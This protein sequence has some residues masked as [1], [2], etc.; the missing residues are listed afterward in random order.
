[1]T[2]KIR[3]ERVGTHRTIETRDYKKIDSDKFLNDLVQQPWDL[4]SLEPNPTAM[5][6]AWK[7]LFMEIVDKHAPLK[8]KR[9][10][11]K[12]SPWITYDLMRKIYK[13]NY[14]KKKAIIENNAASW[15]QYKQARNETNNAIKSA[16]RQ[17]FL[18]N[19]ELNKKNSS[20]TWKL[21]NELSSRKSCTNRN[22]TEIKTDDETINS[23]PEIAEAFNNF[24][25]S[26]GPNLA[27]K[28]SPSNIDPESYL[29]PTK[30]AFS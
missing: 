14:L 10:S 16:K 20:K 19:L 22:I 5:W 3:Y 12:H 11:K 28:L 6:D 17:Y 7:T 27:S 15:E 13:R 30:T 2:I 24:F 23:A 9:I 18:H 29:Q 1:M 8:T 4:I 21:I 26:I 25:T